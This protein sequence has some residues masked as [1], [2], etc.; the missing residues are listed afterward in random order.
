MFRITIRN[1]NTFDIC[2]QTS[3]DRMEVL[4]SVHEPYDEMVASR[5]VLEI[6][7][8]ENSYTWHILHEMLEEEKKLRAKCSHVVVFSYSQLDK[9]DA[10]LSIFRFFADQF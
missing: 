5:I 9:T 7:D 10:F 1:T 6:H 8:S 3:Q 2:G 4:S